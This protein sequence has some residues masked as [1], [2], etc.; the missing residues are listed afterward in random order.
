MSTTEAQGMLVAM[1]F[2]PERA[3]AALREC[4]GNLENAA[5]LLLA[6]GGEGGGDGG[7]DG[8]GAGDNGAT[9]GTASSTAS[10]I[11]N[12]TTMI[13]CPLSQYSVDNGKSACTCIALNAAETFLQH[14]AAEADTSATMA[15]GGSLQKSLNAEFLQ[16]A[17]LQGVNKYNQIMTSGTGASVNPSFEHLSPEEVLQTGAFQSLELDQQDNGG[18][19]GILQGML[20]NDSLGLRALMSS[21]LQSPTYWTCALITKPPETIVCCIPPSSKN[22]GTKAKLTRPFILIDSHPRQM[23]FGAG[24]SY[25]RMHASMDDLLASLEAL[26]PPTNLGPDIPEMMAAM[27]NQFDLYCLR[28]TKSRGV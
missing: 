14:A 10:T 23:Q 2:S 25:I 21:R 13:V 18:D 22:D 17:I 6:G 19:G 16:D 11:I 5:N 27:Y 7:G 15:T 28:Y 3:E 20:G 4:G 26:F 1:G 8:D 9:R 24:G 12:D